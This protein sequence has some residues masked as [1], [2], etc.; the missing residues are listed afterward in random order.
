MKVAIQNTITGNRRFVEI[1]ETTSLIGRPENGRELPAIGINSPLVSRQQA[2]LSHKE[3]E[4]TLEHL[5]SNDTQLGNLVLEPGKYYKVKPGDEIRIAEFVVSLV[6][7]SAAEVQA[8]LSRLELDAME[9]ENEVHDQLLERMDL[10]RGDSATDL[11]SLESRDQIEEHLDDLLETAIQGAAPELLDHILKA[12]I[13]QR[14]I[15][16]VTASETD[17]GAERQLRGEYATLAFEE[18]LAEILGRIGKEC[19]LTLDPKDMQIDTE[20]LDEHFE[21]MFEAHRLEISDGLRKYVVIRAIK[22]DIIDVIYG[23]GPLQDLMEMDSVSE[24]MVVARDQIFIEKFGVI[25][26]A[27]RAF[28]SD[29]LLMS[30]IERIVAPIGRR[31]DRV[32]RWWT[33]ICRTARG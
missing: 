15:W 32:R 33:R 31:I 27:R 3:G 13:N 10:R 24:V 18:K 30:V 4:W 12:H 9:F 1:E 5:G 6:D 22:Q 2:R 16:R 23:L 28:F 29:E 14:L 7:D 8:Q 25:E 26:D 20:R 21:A 19:E 11:Q 17:R